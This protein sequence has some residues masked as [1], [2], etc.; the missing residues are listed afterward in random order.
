MIIPPKK[1]K[2]K[3]YLEEAG[4]P[5][6]DEKVEQIAQLGSRLVQQAGGCVE[7]GKKMQG[8]RMRRLQPNLGFPEQYGYLYPAIRDPLCEIFTAWGGPV[9]PKCHSVSQ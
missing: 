4:C 1:R 2:A 8:L 6:S 5:F 3:K 7:T 9:T